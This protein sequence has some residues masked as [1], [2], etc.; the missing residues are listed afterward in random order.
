MERISI[1]LEI[2]ERI[3]C[4]P[5]SDLKIEM[6]LSL[7]EKQIISLSAVEKIGISLSV[8]ESI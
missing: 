6:D 8:E 7:V 4:V 3:Q 1:D 5:T 2:V